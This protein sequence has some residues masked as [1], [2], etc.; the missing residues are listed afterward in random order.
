MASLGHSE[1]IWV[2]ILCFNSTL[3]WKDRC[4]DSFLDTIGPHGYQSDGLQY[5]QQT[6]CSRYNNLSGSVNR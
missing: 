2:L 6:W 5:L 1:L 4:S 3:K